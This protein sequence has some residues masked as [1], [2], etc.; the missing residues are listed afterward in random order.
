VPPAAM[1]A[2][3]SLG[4]GLLQQAVAVGAAPAAEPVGQAAHM[5]SYLPDVLA[6][7]PDLLLGDGWLAPNGNGTHPLL[8][9]HGDADDFMNLTRLAS[10]SQ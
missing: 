2:G 5:G 9:E 10:L 6:G 8:S 7:S 4:P 3:P 1:A